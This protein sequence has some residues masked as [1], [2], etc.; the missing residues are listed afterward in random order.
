MA[1]APKLTK[2][3]RQN[4]SED[5]IH[6]LEGLEAVRM[7]A[8]MYLGDLGAPMVYR[9]LKEVVDNF[10]DEYQAGRNTGGFVSFSLKNNRYVVADYAEGIPV[11]I[12]KLDD[13]K[14]LSTLTIVMTKL[15]AGG[16]FNADAYKTS[17]G[18]HGVGVSA[19]NALSEKFTVYTKRDGQWY[20]QCFGKGKIL[21]EVT[22]LKNDKEIITTFPWL[23]ACAKKLGTVIEFFPDQSVISVDAHRTDKT[24]NKKYEKAMLDWKFAGTWLQN[25]A[26]LNQG[27]EITFHDI[28]K[29]RQR[30]FLNKKGLMALV[31]KDI[32]EHEFTPLSAKAKFEFISDYLVV[33]LQWTN[34]HDRDH[35]QSFVN[36]SPTIDHGTHVKGF[37]DALMEALKPFFPKKKMKDFKPDDLLTGCV[38]LMNWKMNSAAFSGQVKDKLVSKV[39]DQVYK[40]LLK[41]LTDFFAKN[42]SLAKTIIKTAETAGSARLELQNIMKSMTDVKKGSRNMLPA[43]L[44]EAPSCKPEDRE[45]YV[46]EGDSAGGTA[47]N[48]RNINQEVLKLSGKIPNAL[49]TSLPKLLSNQR[50]Q[51]IIISLGADPKSLDPKK[52]NPTFSCDNLRVSRV[53]LLSDADPD[54]SHINSLLIA[55]FWRLFP[56]LILQGR[57][58]AVD[59]PLYNALHKGKH[60]GGHTIAECFA[61]M[62]K[63]KV[64]RNIMFR[65]KGWGEVDAKLLDPMAFAPSTRKL[66]R[67]SEESDKTAIAFYR[68]FVG[69]DASARRKI[70]G[71]NA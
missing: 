67:I 29:D 62:D 35:F 49:N 1:K 54:G 7:N 45:M 66:I 19:V 60:Y 48:A 21:S 52:E 34:H 36:S 9:M 64:P 20:K 63:D 38:C 55:F 16:K 46:V 39:D 40:L 13:G 44:F 11:G 37:R 33:A 57:L 68:A 5:N 58:Y 23:K 42:K 12:K 31:D 27:L 8:S 47:K 6:V 3:K 28:D 61:A 14:K 71:I 17:G 50:I 59:A 51:D 2:T 4:Y 56:D 22:K 41:P 18:T 15:H 26:M 30:T 53:I 10:G 70:L 69:E 32:E 25:V 65:A 43:A 24:K